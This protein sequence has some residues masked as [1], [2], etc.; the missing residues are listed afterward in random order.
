LMFRMA[1]INDFKCEAVTIDGLD[2]L[3]V[4]VEIRRETDAVGTVT[5]VERE[6]KRVFEITPKVVTLGLGTLAREF[7][8]SVKAPRILDLRSEMSAVAPDK[9][10]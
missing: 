6:I 5:L 4:S 7:E 2:V 8:G 3:R 9:N 10:S 1:A